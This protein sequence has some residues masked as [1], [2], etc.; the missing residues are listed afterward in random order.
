MSFFEKL[1]V[2]KQIHSVHVDSEVTYIMLSDGTHVT[3][4]GLVLVEPECPP[5]IAENPATDFKHEIGAELRS[6]S[7]LR[8][9]NTKSF[10]QHQ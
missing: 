4:R 3:I 5:G 7:G 2:G 9:P 1:L 8:L 10:D 6:L